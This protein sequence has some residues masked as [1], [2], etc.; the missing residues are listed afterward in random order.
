MVFKAAGIAVAFA[1]ASPATLFFSR[2]SDGTAAVEP[3]AGIL[4]AGLI[5]SPHAAFRW[6]TIALS[7]AG[8]ILISLSFGRP[9]V[10]SL[11]LAAARVFEASVA[12]QII[13]VQRGSPIDLSK[14][15]PLMHFSTAAIAASLVPA[16]LL[17]VA[18]PVSQAAPLHTVFGTRFV[19]EA[20]GLLIVTPPIVLLL[21]RGPGDDGTGLTAEAVGHYSLLLISI[22]IVLG[23]THIAMALVPILTLILLACRLGPTHASTATLLTATIIMVLSGLGLGPTSAAVGVEANVRMQIMQLLIFGAFLSGLPLA[24]LVA[25]HRH[26]RAKLAS[27]FLRRDR[28]SSALVAGRMQLRAALGYMA[29]GLCMFD[30]GGRM[31]VFN[32]RF[33]QI[34]GLP[35][36]ALKIGMTYDHLIRVCAATGITSLRVDVRRQTKREIEILQQLSDGRYVLISER[37][38]ADGGRVCTYTDVTKEQQSERRLKR[39][40]EQDELTGLANRALFRER[41][42][43]AVARARG[44][45]TL[46]VLFIDLDNFKYVNDTFGHATGD[47]LLKIVAGRLRSGLRETDTIARLGG[48]EFAIL[49]PDE[50]NL[51][52]AELVSERIKDLM[53]APVCIEGQE[54]RIGASI[55][56]GV[57]PI[58]GA[59]SSELLRRADVALYSAKTER[60]GGYKIFTAEMDQRMRIRRQIEQELRQALA[61]EAFDVHYQPIVRLATREVVGLEALIRWRHPQRGMVAPDEFIPI[62]E[63]T[64]LIVPIGNWVLARACREA[65]LWPE[66]VKVA[67][68]ISCAQFNY[69]GLKTRI[70]AALV[71]S[72]LPAGRLQLE[73]T[74]SAVMADSTKASALLSELQDLGVA[75]VMDDFGTGNSSLGCLRSYRF[76][77]LKIDRS[78]VKDLTTSLEARSILATIVRLAETLGMQTTAEGIESAEQFELVKAEGCNEMQGYYFSS[79]RPAAEIS[80]FFQSS[81]RDTSS[82]A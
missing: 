79:P 80:Q 53:G 19:S 13:T 8:D 24:A 49:L 11:L 66:H 23:Q 6:L 1:L 35:R 27:E 21:R 32:N 17:A 18:V 33:L 61:D 70:E 51:V 30:A 64:G 15:G 57:H 41:I 72:G 25:E 81:P 59:T 68:N 39:L 3:A 43:C 34:Y 26:L 48:D 20:L 69:P 75:I 10:A 52:S 54:I 4:L 40:A 74:E 29:Q 65:T 14:I 55:G 60:R 77:K 38:L 76:D 67:V 16:F 9:F 73:I 28:L 2:S 31:V 71:N 12:Y 63:E 5:L 42:D 46:T 7:A 50:D 37:H 62:A 45:K 22:V 78:F 58:E 47:E 82:A 36:G 56:I 44:S